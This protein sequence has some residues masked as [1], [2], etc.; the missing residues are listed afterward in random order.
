MLRSCTE[1]RQIGKE[2]PF[3]QSYQADT[4]I[5]E[6]KAK[7]TSDQQGERISPLVDGVPRIG[8]ISIDL[9]SA[10]ACQR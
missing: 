9:L 5:Q 2:Q 8:T 4:L 6:W 7:A 10:A 3:L 1:P